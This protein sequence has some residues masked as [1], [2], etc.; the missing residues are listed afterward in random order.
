MHLVPDVLV[1]LSPAVVCM[2]VA[3]CIASAAPHGVEETKDSAT[4]ADVWLMS[5]AESDHG[6]WDDD[7]PLSQEPVASALP[8]AARQY[9]QGDRVYWKKSRS[10]D[11]DKKHVRYGDRARVIGVD[12][13]DGTIYVKFGDSERP[14]SSCSVDEVSSCGAPRPL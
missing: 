8:T 13:S 5:D 2:A 1:L 11:R 9:Q 10:N 6:S 7:D 3:C 14:T 12:S 4:L